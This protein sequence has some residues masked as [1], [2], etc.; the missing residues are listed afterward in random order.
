MNDAPYLKQADVG[1]AMGNKGTEA[2]KEAAQVVLADDNFATIVA[3]IYEGL[4][5]HDNIRKVIAWT[6]PTNGG[7]AP[8][9]VAAMVFVMMPTLVCVCARLQLLRA[10]L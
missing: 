10:S 5:V 9:I 2:A 6:I 1:I 3:A 4:T 8:A 7:V